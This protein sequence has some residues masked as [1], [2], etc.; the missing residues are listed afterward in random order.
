MK[1]LFGAYVIRLVAG[2]F[3]MV[4]CSG[5]ATGYN[6]AWNSFVDPTPDD[7]FSGKWQGSWLSAYN[8][9]QG[10]LRAMITQTEE[11][12]YLAQFHATYAKVLQFKHSN[13]FTARRQGEIIV[14]EGENDLG[15]LAGGL[16]N[17]YGKVEGAAFTATYKA[18]K[19]HG[20]FRMRR[21]AD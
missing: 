16:F 9:H 21:V 10:G 15:K 3:L 19:D 1:L 17:Y 7:A 8:G 4:L 13:V 2:L 20:M 12:Q 14:F 18:E 11:D 6:R 5:C